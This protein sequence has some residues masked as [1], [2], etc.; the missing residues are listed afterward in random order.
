MSKADYQAYLASREWAILKNAVRERACG[1]CERCLASPIQSTHHLTYERIYHEELTD[2]LGVCDPCH[3][4][5][6]GKED[7]DPDETRDWSIHMLPAGTAERSGWPR[8]SSMP[9]HAASVVRLGIDCSVCDLYEMQFPVWL[10]DR[11]IIGHDEITVIAPSQADYEF[12][13]SMGAWESLDQLKLKGDHE[14]LGSAK[15]RIPVI[16]QRI[17]DSNRRIAEE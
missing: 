15:Q 8:S 7:L 12:M 17:I 1:I 11:E 16:A 13:F 5:L 10:D 6:S 2:L 14:P 4:W 3:K 9:T